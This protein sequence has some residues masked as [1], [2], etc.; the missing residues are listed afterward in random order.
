MRYLIFRISLTALAMLPLRIN[1]SVGAIIGWLL[2][3]RPNEFKQTAVI[4]LRLCFPEYDHQ[5]IKTLLRQTLIETGKSFTELGPVW[6]WPKQRILNKIKKV[7]NLELVH[8]A[9]NQQRGLI[10][11][12]PHL[13][14]W[15]LNG[16]YCA[17]ILPLTSLY[18]PPRFSS[19]EKFL[20]KARERTG[21]TLV[22]TNTTGVKALY[23]T[24]NRKHV[25]GILPD[26]DAGESGV[27]APFF[28]VNANT[29]KLIPRLISK[30]RAPVVMVYA[31]RLPRGQGYNIHFIKPDENIYSSDLNIAATAMNHSVEQ[32]IRQNI[33]QYQWSYKRFKRNVDGKASPYQ[34][35][36]L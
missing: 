16:L 23:A 9:L 32:C 20:T 31:Q 19:I 2:Y 11:L 7:E 34:Q 28:G 35:P 1:H 29:V 24:I 25:V 22:P 21:G 10:I 4:N 8:D 33:D 5:Q 6:M 15:E 17:D 13:G 30:T 26:Q 12:T 36:H 27:F 14:C 3:I 18:R